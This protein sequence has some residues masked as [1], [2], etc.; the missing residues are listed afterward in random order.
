MWLSKQPYGSFRMFSPWVIITEYV[1][2]V[3][4]C[5]MHEGEALFS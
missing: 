1:T 4:R 5:F 3:E 2:H